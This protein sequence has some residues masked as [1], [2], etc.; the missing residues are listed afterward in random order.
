M[1]LKLHEINEKT[2]SSKQAFE[3]IFYVGKHKY[4]LVQRQEDEKA[5]HTLIIY[6]PP[7]AEIDGDLATPCAYINW[8][9]T[10]ANISM[11]NFH[12][13]EA[14]MYLRQNELDWF[15]E[16]EGNEYV[17]YFMGFDEFEY[18]EM[19]DIFNWDFAEDAKTPDDFTFEDMI[20]DY[21]L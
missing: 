14:I 12:G 3:D 9:A 21:S 20:S 15:Q 2:Y 17:H 11:D 4:R 1:K 5:G 6:E 19:K 16:H 13:I 7:E 18:E 8:Q 10:S